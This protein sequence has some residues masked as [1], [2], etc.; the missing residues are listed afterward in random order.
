VGDDDRTDPPEQC[1]GHAEC[2]S[3]A[4]EHHHETDVADPPNGID[5]GEA[6]QHPLQDDHCNDRQ[7]AAQTAHHHPAEHHL[8][9]DR[10]SDHGR[11]HQR[12][13][14]GAIGPNLVDA[15]GVAHQ[16]HS[17]AQH[18]RSDGEL[19]CDR[20]EPDHRPPPQIGESRLQ[21]DVGSEVPG[22]PSPTDVTTPPQR[23][24]VADDGQQRH[25][26]RDGPTEADDGVE[27]ELRGDQRH[28]EHTDRPDRR[29]HRQRRM[30]PARSGRGG[31]DGTDR[32]AGNRWRERGTH[33]RVGCCRSFTAISGRHQYSVKTA[34]ER[35]ATTR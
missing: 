33:R 14:V 1:D 28:R 9:H 35:T 8:L 16:R 13:H 15:L 11:D 29:H 22:P 24:P 23:R 6:E 30:W 7:A 3:H 31:A 32:R 4:R 27:E 17:E 12:H 2:D 34:S 10:G 18:D 20:T 26:H 21:S 19:R 5:V 25:V